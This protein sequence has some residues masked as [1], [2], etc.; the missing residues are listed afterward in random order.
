M[1]EEDNVPSQPPESPP[2]PVAE[3]P[4]PP[5]TLPAPDIELVDHEFKSLTEKEME[6]RGW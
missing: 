3:S 1:S 4:S 6:R 5:P 2:P